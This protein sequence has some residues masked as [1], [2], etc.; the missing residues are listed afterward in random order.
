MWA[1]PFKRRPL[2]QIKCAQRVV[3]EPVPPEPIGLAPGV[4]EPVGPIEPD[5]PVPDEPEEPVPEE[6]LPD[7]GF[8]AWNLAHS[9][10]FMLLDILH[11]SAVI[12]PPVPLGAVV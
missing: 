6:P 12:A 5:D 7:D 1:A 9:G 4:P 10:L 3:P 2:R 11:W 8:W